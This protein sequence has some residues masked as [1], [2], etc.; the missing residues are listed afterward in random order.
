MLQADKSAFKAKK[1]GANKQK[2]GQGKGVKGNGK[3]I[4][5]VDSIDFNKKIL[6]GESG[7]CSRNRENAT[8]CVR[9]IPQLP[10]I[11]GSRQSPSQRPTTCFCTRNPAHKAKQED[12]LKSPEISFS[13]VSRRY[14]HFHLTLFHSRSNVRFNDDRRHLP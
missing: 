5:D 8:D 10:G 13:L 14:S 3:P 7:T 6:H 4:I 1:I 11:L 12:R 9:M 2:P